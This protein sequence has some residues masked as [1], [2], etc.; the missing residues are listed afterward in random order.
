MNCPNCK[1]NLPDNA[2]TCP[3]CGYSFIEQSNKTN[4]NSNQISSLYSTTISDTQNNQP[5]D[6]IES[7]PRLDNEISTPTTSETNILDTSVNND[8]ASTNNVVEQVPNNVVEQNPNNIFGNTVNT[9]VAM[10]NNV[11][12]QVPNNVVEQNPNNIFGTPV[13]NQIQNATAIPMPQLIPVDSEE[14]KNV[15]QKV[16]VTENTISKEESKQIP[17]VELE[18]KKNK[19]ASSKLGNSIVIILIVLV[20][21]VTAIIVSYFKIT[22]QKPIEEAGIQEINVNGLLGTVPPG[23]NFLSSIDASTG[24]NDIDALFFNDKQ[25]SKIKI[26]EKEE[27]DYNTILS[28]RNIILKKINN[29]NKKHFTVNV[30]SANHVEYLIYSGIHK[31]QNHILIFLKYNDGILAGEGDYSSST[32]LTTIIDF[33]TTIKKSNKSNYK[34]INEGSL[35]DIISEDLIE[36]QKETKEEKKEKKEQIKPKEE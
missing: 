29:G 5:Q 34:I 4:I 22:A 13:T 23:W 12:E 2:S 9:N 6:N 27:I 11:V 24:I 16:P 17:N 21:T 31:E 35:L 8:I 14:V 33:I 15:A 32:D 28:K 3:Y 30:S 26:Y 1:N 36:A 18:D 20:L 7:I 19:K 10:P 25:D